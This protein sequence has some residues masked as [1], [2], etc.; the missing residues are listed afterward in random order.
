MSS[1]ALAGVTL[2]NYAGFVAQLCIYSNLRWQENAATRF[3]RGIFLLAARRLLKP[4][5]MQPSCPEVRTGLEA[6]EEGQ[7]TFS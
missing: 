6:S 2:D 5:W 1:R 7:L 3:S 4:P